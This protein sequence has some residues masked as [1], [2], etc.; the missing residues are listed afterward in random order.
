MSEY[1]S[2]RG[3]GIPPAQR[4]DAFA[5]VTPISGRTRTN[6]SPAQSN[7]Q[8]ITMSSA[9]RNGETE[10]WVREQFEPY[11]AEHGVR[12]ELLLSGA[13]IMDDPT[14][15]GLHPQTMRQMDAIIEKITA[16]KKTKSGGR[17]AVVS[18]MAG[19]RMSS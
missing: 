13:R 19:R 5:K 1:N 6:S 10:R 11:R 15:A 3:A 4:R 12:V 9:P 17:L 2:Q 8:P 7:S 18:A 16:K 14:K